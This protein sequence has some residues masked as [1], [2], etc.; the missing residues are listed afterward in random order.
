MEPSDNRKIKGKYLPIKLPFAATGVLLLTLDRFD[1]PGWAWGGLLCLTA[2]WWL[3][4]VIT[5][6]KSE[7][8]DPIFMPKADIMQ[9]LTQALEDSIKESVDENE[10]IN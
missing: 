4:V 10:R 7:Y 8:R 6:I 9:S 3:G 1:A 2:L 5:R